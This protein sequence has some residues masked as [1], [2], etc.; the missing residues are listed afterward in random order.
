MTFAMTRV[1]LGI[2]IGVIAAG[3]VAQLPSLA[4]FIA[5]ASTACLLLLAGQRVLAAV[6]CGAVYALAW[7]AMGCNAR[8]PDAATGGVWHVSGRVVGLAANDER[9][10][11]FDFELDPVASLPGVERIRLSWY[12]APPPA[13]DARCT[14]RVRLQRVHGFANPGGFDAEAWSL[15]R[16]IGAT[17]YVRDDS[18]NRCVGPVAVSVAT[19]RDRLRGELRATGLQHAAELVALVLGDGSDLSAAQWLVL[20][21]TGTVHLIV[22]SGLHITMIAIAVFTMCAWVL[23]AWP[24]LLRRCGARAPA[25][26]AAAAFT[27][28]YCALAGFSVPTVRAMIMAGFGLAATAL[29][30][31]SQWHAGLALALAAVHLWQPLA[32]REPGFWLSFV[33][34]LALLHATA[35]RTERNEATWRR[36]LRVWA[37]TQWLMLIVFT[38]LLLLVFGNAPLISPLANLVAEPLVSLVIVPLAGLGTLLLPFSKVLAWP[39]LELADRLVAFLWWYLQALAPLGRVTALHG[40]AAPSVRLLVGVLAVAPRGTPGR[41][42][43]PLLA[44][45]ALL[46]VPADVPREGELHVQVF[47][48]GQG[49]AALLTTAR[50]ALLVDTGP[51]FGPDFEAGSAILAPALLSQ[52]IARLDA[53]VVSHADQDHAGG[54]PGV[55]ARLSIAQVWEPYAP[56][57]P[58]VLTPRFCRDGER[59]Q[60]DGVD[61]F[62]LGPAPPLAAIENDRSCVLLARASN[63]DTALLPGDIS[64]RQEA[65]LLSDHQPLL[66]HLALLVAAH[67]G[68]KSSS[69]LAFV[70]ATQAATVVFSAGWHSRF[71]HPDPQVVARF[72]GVGSDQWTTGEAGAVA[73]HSG[74]RTARAQRCEERRPWR[75]LPVSCAAAR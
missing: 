2:A 13:S 41:T 62:M 25:A 52:G 45:A 39:A 36:W 47:D 29:Q 40:A 72:A 50:H 61:F 4:V 22:I 37:R 15:T 65:R 14:L 6:G 75:S 59:W 49:S 33:S 8:L 24:W 51:R 12:D 34:V 48:V 70:T 28:G 73:W 27:V 10:S 71:G 7:I 74:D 30:R 35:T 32:W 58:G 42:L 23:R 9:R 67:H 31:R 55:A 60:W 66:G 3:Q 46:A 17:G 63:G 26:V 54:F 69:S 1:A 57:V 38:P 21:Q 20:Q 44:A 18:A 56:M 53:V 43:V 16:G 19:V 64:V 5:V 68:S 11:V